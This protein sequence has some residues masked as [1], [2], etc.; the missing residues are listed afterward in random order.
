MYIA[1][2]KKNIEFG[3]WSTFNL[4]LVGWGFQLSNQRKTLLFITIIFIIR[5][6][7]ASDNRMVIAHWK[8]SNY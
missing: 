1:R 7:P 3:Q 8:D 6:N 4:I 2:V 5:I